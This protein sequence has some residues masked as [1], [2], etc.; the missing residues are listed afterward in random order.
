MSC[1]NDRPAFA[2]ETTPG[3]ESAQAINPVF[4]PIRRFPDRSA[5]TDFRRRYRRAR[6]RRSRNLSRPSSPRAGATPH[7]GSRRPGSPWAASDPA[8]S[9]RDHNSNALRTGSITAI[10]A[11]LAEVIEMQAMGLAIHAHPS[12]CIP[13][14]AA[15]GSFGALGRM[16]LGTV[17]LLFRQLICELLVATRRHGRFRKADDRGPVA[18]NTWPPGLNQRG[19]R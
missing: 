12:R 4:R 13:D 19:N 14:S 10:A 9:G 15:N 11:K 1:R 17:M 2:D 18:A 6:S 16:K 8:P 7:S 3:S 5:R